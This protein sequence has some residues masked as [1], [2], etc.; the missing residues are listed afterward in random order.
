LDGKW[1]QEYWAFAGLGFLIIVAYMDPGN[2]ATDLPGV[3][4]NV[5]PSIYFSKFFF[6]F[7][8]KKKFVNKLG[9]I[10]TLRNMFVI[11]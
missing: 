3:N 5:Y 6:M 11:L 9:H 7:H 8:L 1:Y 2:W 4:V 10:L